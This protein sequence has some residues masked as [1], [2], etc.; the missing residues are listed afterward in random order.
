MVAGAA[1]QRRST[2]A[3]PLGWLVEIGAP[4]TT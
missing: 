3:P 2:A 4:G 1:T